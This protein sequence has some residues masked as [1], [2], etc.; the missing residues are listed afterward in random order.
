MPATRPDRRSQWH[1]RRRAGVVASVLIASVTLSGCASSIHVVPA[2]DAAN[3]VCASVVLALPEVL[4]G[5]HR[6]STTSQ[7]TAAWGDTTTSVVLRC[8]VT[9]LGPTTDPCV[10][11][12][13][14]AG[15]SVDWVVTANGSR[16]GGS[17][18]FVTYGRTPSVELTIPQSLAADQPDTILM[19]VGQA[20]DVVPPQRAC[21]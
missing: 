3:P 7:G 2:P 5:L 1:P 14:I 15:T 13:D 4:A 12:T 17:W 9:P 21:T 16:A 10:T 11:I 20:A 6:I 19:E 18:T 8:G